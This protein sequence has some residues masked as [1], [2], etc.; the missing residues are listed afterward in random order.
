[1]STDSDTTREAPQ[2]KSAE[3]RSSVHSTVAPAD[4]AKEARRRRAAIRQVVLW[5][6]SFFVVGA[7]RARRWVLC[8]LLTGSLA[9]LAYTSYLL[10]EQRHQQAATSQALDTAR[11]YAATLTTTDQSAI[12]QNIQ[13]VLD[14]ATAD[15][16]DTYGRAASQLRKMLIDNKVSTTGTVTDAAVIGADGNDVEVLLAVAQDVSSAEA[17]EPRTDSL[18]VTMTMRHIDGRWLAADVALAGGQDQP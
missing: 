3:G 2:V 6:V 9:A 4:H 7:R 17:P 14:G 1:M 10:Y 5:A 16:K 15:F 13:Q 8:I 18:S 11:T 12:D